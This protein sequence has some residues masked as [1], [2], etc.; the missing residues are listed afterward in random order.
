MSFNRATT[1]IAALLLSSGLSVTAFATPQYRI[2]FHDTQNSIPDVL[3][4]YGISAGPTSTGTLSFDGYT[5]SVNLNSN[6][7]GTATLGTLSQSFTFSGSR[8]GANRDFLSNVTIVDS[9]NPNAVI[10]FA[11]PNIAGGSYSLV[12]D[13]ANTANASITAGQTQVFATAN[14]A[15]A[16]NN[17][18]PF[19]GSGNSP[20]S[21][22]PIAP[23][24]QGY[25]LGTNIVFS[26]IVANGAAGLS[27]ITASSTSSVQSIPPTGVPEPASLALL[28]AGLLS[29]G[30]LRRRAK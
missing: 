18:N 9:S 10:R 7:P 13:S 21:T 24:S 20:T 19:L 26:G 2:A 11:L 28:G 29:A 25:T 27:S 22:A 23:N 6:Y 16:A 14:E 5:F 12:S 17:A 15:T 4:F 8:T 1:T 30:M 3:N